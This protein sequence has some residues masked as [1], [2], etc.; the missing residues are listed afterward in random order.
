MT[1]FPKNLGQAPVAISDFP[2]PASSLTASAMRG[3][4][5]L[6]EIARALAEGESVLSDSAPDESVV[7]DDGA[8]GLAPVDPIALALRAYA[9]LGVSMGQTTT[10]FAT[11]ATGS[12][13]MYA[14][15]E[16]DPTAEQMTPMSGCSCMACMSAASSGSGG[17]PNGAPGAAVSLQ[18]LANY[19]RVTFWSDFDNQGV[20]YYNVT[21]SGTG[22]NN[23]T[24]YYNVT[25]TPSGGVSTYYG[26][27]TDTNGVSA[28]RATLIRDA[29]AF[30]EELLG[31][32]FVE[33]TSTGTS[34]DFFFIDNDA[35]RAWQAPKFHSGTG[36]AIDH[37]VINV[38]SGWQG[39][40]SDIN[41]YTYQTF[42]HEIGHALG[43]GHQ[44]LYNAGSGA[45]TYNNSAI[46]ANDSW[47]Q[48]MMSYFDQSQNTEFSDDSHARLLGPSAADFIALNN[49]YSGQGYG[50]NNAFTGDTVY[51]VGTNIT[52][53]VNRQ[54]NQL[55]DL[56]DT[57]FFT[58]V[59][60]GGNDTVDFS[61]YN[62]NQ[63]INL[64]ITLTSD[65][66]PTFSS[67]GGLS[68]NMALAADTIIE[69]ATTGGGNDTI[70]GNQYANTLTGNAGADLLYG[71]TGHDWLT[72]GSGVDTLYGGSGDDSLFGGADNDRMFSESGN[73]YMKGGAGNDTLFGDS[74]VDTMMG[75]DGDDR[76]V[77]YT[78]STFGGAVFFGGV[79]TDVFE[80]NGTGTLDLRNSTLTGFE[81]LEFFANSS[82][83]KTVRITGAQAVAL[84]TAARIDGNNSADSDDVL[85]IHLADSATTALDM[86]GW[87]MQDWSQSSNNN[88]FLGVLG[89]A[90]AETVTG[91]SRND[92]ISL[93][94]G[95]DVGYGGAG[96]DTLKGGAGNDTLYGGS[97]IDQL[98]GED[99]DDLLYGA[100]TASTSVFY[101]GSGG[102]VFYKASGT[103]SGNSESW[104]GG[105]GTDWLVWTNSTIGST[106]VVNLATGF[107]TSVSSTRDVVQ[108]VESVLLENGAGV[109][110]DGNANWI[111]ATGN[112]ANDLDGG[113]GDDTLKGGAGDDTLRGGTGID[114]LAGEDGN[115]TIYDGDSA[116][117]A[118]S[119][120]GG[121]GDD[122]LVKESST[123]PNALKVWDGGDG[124]DTFDFAN[125]FGSTRVV[126][127]ADGRIYT[128]GQGRDFLS[129]IENVVVRNQAGIVGDGGANWLRAV[130]AFANMIDGGAGND[131]ID[132]GDGDDSLYGGLGDD[133]ML[134]GTGN[135]GMEGGDGNDTMLGG[136]GVDTMLGQAG[137]D[138]M[139]GGADND[140]VHGSDGNDVLFGEQ[141]DDLLSGEVGNDILHGGDGNDVAY[142][143]EGADTLFGGAGADQLFGD[144]GGD[145]LSGGVGNDTLYGGGGADSLYGDDGD[146]LF[147]TY[148]GEGLDNYYGG[149]GT[150]T[151]DV[152]ATNNNYIMDL[153]AGTYA[154]GA[155]NRAMES[156]ETLV[157]GGGAD[158]VFGGVGA[159]TMYGGGNADEL[160]GGGGAD[161]LYGDAGNDMLYGGNWAD[162]FYGGT[163]DDV[164]YAGNGLDSLFGGAARDVLY[165]G[166]GAA[167]LSG[168]G[169][170]DVIHIDDVFT[171]SAIA[172]GGGGNR[173]VINFS[174]VLG[175]V[176][177]DMVAGTATDG[178]FS[179]SMSGFEDV[180]GSNNADTIAGDGG[181]NKIA[182]SGGHDL[183]HG[184]DGADTILAGA[185]N[186][187]VYGGAGSDSLVSGG[188]AD[189][190]FGEGAND[191]LEGLLGNDVLDGGNGADLL[192]GGDG[193][194]TL[195]GG[196]G[197]DTL[198]GGAGRDVFVFNTV[199]EIGLGATS[200][201][202]LDHVSG[203]DRFDFSGFASAL[204]FIGTNAFSGSA[205]E[206]R[207]FSLGGVGYLAGDTSGNGVA[208]FEILLI[209]G[210]SVAAGDL[211]L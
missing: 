197:A 195:I 46:F 68:K 100:A 40:E 49:L 57:N 132:G 36:G 145:V 102:D 134:G 26:T 82:S 194:D 152:S 119:I 185:G 150:D 146:D 159:E 16:A 148:A 126:N 200:D 56:A 12:G 155:N 38:A 20:Q 161:V 120:Y 98:H 78:T 65:L 172:D 83:D 173:D 71:A 176:A 174:G 79:G 9:P 118:D 63:S 170:N 39:G 169:G 96:N 211:I 205:G 92:F 69:N 193:N 51:G 111:S 125:Q 198:I 199:A 10:E 32:N 160:Q 153:V 131:T 133:S 41:G 8:P 142:G 147:I 113:A 138:T 135:D 103:T 61:N 50:I 47:A 181:S 140:F 141:G 64:T 190:L 164:L 136:A 13:G 175:G 86:S 30:Y 94:G 5:P 129:N 151:V 178:V 156:I 210:A 117:G 80:M 62:V 109:V 112:F 14:L 192:D 121:M 29:F 3:T 110:G 90:A 123:L 44:G 107:I 91:T 168:D 73:D 24:L 77:V 93:G 21:N 76:I 2:V 66:R 1:V 104:Y 137:D 154:V 171:G 196:N 45:I 70:I 97:G 48:S 201:R 202:V 19:L 37:S 209:N 15:A 167:Q 189:F 204:T 18:S 89:G 99:G 149:T 116:E 139:Y 60:G 81:E 7:S 17:N 186:D 85:Y 72:G 188:G 157:L 22:A 182:A 115:D 67:V 114:Y 203:E 143:G 27:Y 162:L 52:A 25:G 59:D 87:I 6:D 34:V 158:T 55:A 208:N 54:F 165:S 43:L 128:G 187:T 4:L 124:I 95:A 191:T 184:G 122:W 28:A 106:R 166:S 84:G 75:D 130:G 105:D 33:T 11:F 88:D 207:Y 23:G 58:I 53:A 183:V 108:G 101:G 163:G 127:L 179:I 74:G 35:G 180:V 177:V 206:L 42:L 31:I 144:S